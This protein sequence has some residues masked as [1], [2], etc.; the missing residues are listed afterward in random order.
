MAG[1]LEASLNR[2]DDVDYL[3]ELTARDLEG[4]DVYLLCVSDLVSFSIDARKFLTLAAVALGSEAPDG[5]FEG[6]DTLFEAGYEPE[7]GDVLLGIPLNRT[8]VSRF[9][10]FGDESLTQGVFEG[11]GFPFRTES[12]TELGDRPDLMSICFGVE[13]YRDD[14]CCLT[15]CSTDYVD[16]A[17]AKMALAGRIVEV[18][19]NEQDL[20]NGYE[21]PEMGSDFYD[22]DEYR[23][24]PGVGFYKAPPEEPR[25]WFEL[26]FDEMLRVVLEGTV[27]LC[28]V[29]GRPVIVGSRRGRKP[30]R[31]C[32]DSCKTKA[33][34][35]RREDAIRR[36]WNGVPLDEAVKII[37]PE[38][39][40]SVSRYFDYAEGTLGI[41]VRR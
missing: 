9:G 34:N 30:K 11:G 29:C 21:F 35:I 4:E 17:D 39:E 10:L 25:W 19:M 14:E 24:S 5:L 20:F 2:R 37:G 36:A 41:P 13:N 18:L 12:E 6:V 7:Q 28:P 38:Y 15:V 32:S 22:Y 31:Y 3:D 26:L 16:P 23:Y 27:T 40:Q 33:C 8:G 1:S